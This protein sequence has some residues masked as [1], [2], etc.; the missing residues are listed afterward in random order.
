MRRSRGEG[1]ILWDEEGSTPA[2]GAPSS[3]PYVSPVPLVLSLLRRDRAEETSGAHRYVPEVS[4][5][6]SRRSSDRTRGTGL[7]YG[8]DD[9]A[10]AAGVLPS[11]THPTLTCGDTPNAQVTGVN[12]SR[13]RPTTD[14]RHADEMGTGQHAD[15]EDPNPG[16]R[17]PDALGPVPRHHHQGHHR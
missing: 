12:C 6:R 9:G 16:R 13:S 2:A 7:T 1:P 14:R 3:R 15:P 5:A 11:E 8:R 10:P 17:H 4:S